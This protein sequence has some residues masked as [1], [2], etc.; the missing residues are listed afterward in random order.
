MNL[1]SFILISFVYFLGSSTAWTYGIGY[2][3]LYRPVIAG[4]LAG[5][6]FGDVM[7][8][9]TAGAVVN[10]IYLDFVSTGGSLKGDPCLTGIIAAIGAILFNI[11]SIEAVALAFPFGFLGILIWKYRLNINIYF[12]KKLESSKLNSKN[13][14]F[15]YNAL[16]PQLLLLFMSTLIIL[17]SYFILYLLQSYFNAYYEVLR[18]ILFLSGSFILLN[19]ILSNFIKINNIKLIYMSVAIFI[20]SCFKSLDLF[21]YIIIVFIIYFIFSDYRNGS[22][23]NY[24]EDRL[25]SKCSLFRSWSVWMNFS[26]ACY[27]FERMQGLAFSHMMKN[28]I[29][30]LYDK[31]AERVDRIKYYTDFFNTEPNLGTPIHGYV[32]SLEEDRAKHD[33]IV[34]INSLKKNMMGVVSGLGDSFT[35]TVLT[36]IF[37]L[38]CVFFALSKNIVGTVIVALLLGFIIIYISYTGLIKGYYNGKSGLID[39]INE[40]KNSKLKKVNIKNSKYKK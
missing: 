28:I 31:E 10:I 38:L 29:C 24:S 22:K 30:K 33:N 40:V 21:I 2:Y 32:I 4:M 18:N 37:I 23:V 20:I 17:L 26:H 11:N 36:P 34:D 3:T 14:M 1:I 15:L 39:R 16:L 7:L 12:V 19:S 25:I 27:N 9:L 35:Q 8:G 5:L 6:V 13:S